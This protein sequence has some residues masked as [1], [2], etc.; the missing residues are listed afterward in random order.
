MTE[1]VMKDEIET[2][3]K[4]LAKRVGSIIAG[5]RKARGLTQAQ[6]AER[7]SIEKETIS[8]VETGVI[9]PTL[10]RLAQLAKILD[11]EMADFLRI[12]PPELEDHAASLAGRMEDLSDSQRD[13]M[14]RLFSR[15]SLSIS[16]APIKERKV[17]ENF[18]SD[19]LYSH[20]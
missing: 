14:V 5:I 15:I 8:R 16:R 11:C 19:I 20:S 13:L 1:R 6:L 12:K 9:S 4:Q 7:M 18:L 17:I 2:P 3:D 10:G